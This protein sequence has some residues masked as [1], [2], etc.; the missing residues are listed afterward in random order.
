VLPTA[1]AALFILCAPVW[2][3]A[4]KSS[5]D[6]SAIS[7]RAKGLRLTPTKNSLSDLSITVI[8]SQKKNISLLGVN[9]LEGA[10]VGE[11]YASRI[12]QVAFRDGEVFSTNRE[13]TWVYSRNKQGVDTLRRA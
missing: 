13:G 4:A 5:P 2:T 6:C 12:G 3:Q 9:L 10:C 7:E 8:P 1:V 11:I